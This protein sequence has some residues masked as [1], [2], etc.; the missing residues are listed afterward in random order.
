MSLKYLLT[1]FVTVSIASATESQR[2]FLF[3]SSETKPSIFKILGKIELSTLFLT[4]HNYSNILKY[5]SV[6]INILLKTCRQIY[7]DENTG[8]F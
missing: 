4:I 2:S 5:N 6:K 8:I 1:S 3:F 7:D